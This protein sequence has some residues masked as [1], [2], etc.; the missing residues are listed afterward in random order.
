MAAHAGLEICL[1]QFSYKQPF[2]HSHVF[3]SGGAFLYY[4]SVQAA[5]ARTRPNKTAQ[6]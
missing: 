4:V 3:G 5:V 2:Q 1:K 6:N